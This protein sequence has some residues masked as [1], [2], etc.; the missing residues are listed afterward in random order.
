MSLATG[1][2]EN[3]VSWIDYNIIWSVTFR[4]IGTNQFFLTK[5]RAPLMCLCC[6]AFELHLH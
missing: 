5:G 3:K 6:I 2:K 1:I 4:S